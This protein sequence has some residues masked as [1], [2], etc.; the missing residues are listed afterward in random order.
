MFNH[1]E[2][3][4]NLLQLVPLPVKLA[5]IGYNQ[6]IYVILG[7]YELSW[8]V[9]SSYDIIELRSGTAGGGL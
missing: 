5:A 8:S 2:L 6:R 3:Q 7:Y 1:N 9:K 4:N